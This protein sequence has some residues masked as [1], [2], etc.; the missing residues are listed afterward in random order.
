MHLKEYNYKL[1]LTICGLGRFAIKRIL[2]AIIKSQNV[3]LVSVVSRSNKVTDLPIN[4]QQ[5]PT[6]EKFLESNPI[7]AVYITS[8]N[9][10]HAKQSLQCLEAGLHVLCEKP[11]A[12]NSD[13]CQEMIGVAKKYNLNL[14][15]GHMLRFSPALLVVRKWLQAGLIKSPNAMSMIFHYQ[16][17]EGGR[18]WAFQ[19]G[20]KGG[21]ALMDAGV[22]CIDVMRMLID[23]PIEALEASTDRNSHADGVDRSVKCTL[24]V[25]S[26]KC[27]LDI[28]SQ[29][30]YKTILK[31]GDVKNEIVVDNFAACWGKITVKLNDLKYNKTIKQ[32]IVDVSSIYTEQLQGFSLAVGESGDLSCQD[33]AAAENIYIVES[34]YALDK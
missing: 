6:L 5:F 18:R 14:W 4:V 17:Q 15:V 33:I 30:P 7:G 12:V 26:V 8:P 19:A 29:K 21:G 28:N 23:S 3:E 22:H 2:P 27:T 25:G 11:M 24:A 10:L 31:V 13:D 9:Y 32:E 20:Q 1:P 16:L 34:I